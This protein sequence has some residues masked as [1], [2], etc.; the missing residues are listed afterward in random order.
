[1]QS[2][3]GGRGDTD[4]RRR[5]RVTRRNRGGISMKRVNLAAACTIA[6]LGFATIYAAAQDNFNRRT[7][8]TFSNAVELPGV[9]LQAGTYLFRL[10]DSQSDRHI[11]QVWSQDEK[12]IYASILAVAAER[13][14]P[15]D[16]TV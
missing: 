9:T 11:V 5:R 3:R 7:F 1:M 8:I 15:T 14:E 10:A 12:Q 13:L 2:S 6:V 4:I 16:E